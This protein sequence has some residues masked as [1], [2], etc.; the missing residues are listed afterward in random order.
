MNDVL[1]GP[2][3]EINKRKKVARRGHNRRR[4]SLKNSQAP[5]FAKKTMAEC[6]QQRPG[7]RLRGAAGGMADVDCG[8]V[9]QCAVDEHADEERLPVA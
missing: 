3:A 5:S 6:V 7:L 9:L 1:Y 4:V 8:A 2:S